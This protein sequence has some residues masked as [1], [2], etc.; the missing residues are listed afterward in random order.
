MQFEEI[1]KEVKEIV[2]D[3]LRM[4]CDN[5]FEAVILKEELAKLI[6]RLEKFFGSP[7]WPSKNSLSFQIRELIEGF[8]GVVS[9]QILYFSKEGSDTIFAML[10]PW[11]DGERTTLKIIKKI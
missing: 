2:F 6:A 7:V 8:G 11:Q 10:W 4:D 1:K 9:G 3:K 5:Q